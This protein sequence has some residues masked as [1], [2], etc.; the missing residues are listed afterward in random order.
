MRLWGKW[1]FPPRISAWPRSWYADKGL[2]IYQWATAGLQR[3]QGVER[4]WPFSSPLS[5]WYLTGLVPVSHQGPAHELFQKGCL[6]E[7]S[8]H[9]VCKVQLGQ[10][11]VPI[12]SKLWAVKALP[13][14]LVR[15]HEIHR[16]L[17]PGGEPSLLE[18]QHHTKDYVKKPIRIIRS[19]VPV[20]TYCILLKIRNFLFSVKI[21]YF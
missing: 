20:V 7:A 2:F 3:G 19:S 13:L 4:K 8:I 14:V 6:G 12:P 17:A 11:L 15:F 18:C 21:T 10:G 9:H 5:S 1:A 16:E